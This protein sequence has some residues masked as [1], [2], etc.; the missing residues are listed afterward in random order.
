MFKDAFIDIPDG[1]FIDIFC[2]HVHCGLAQ[3]PA[4]TL[5][6]KPTDIAQQHSSDSS[7]GE[8]M[9]WNLTDLKD[10]YDGAMLV[11]KDVTA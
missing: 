3:S 1:A 5:F 9:A 2:R 7:D 10:R 6:A 4:D 8:T 11:D